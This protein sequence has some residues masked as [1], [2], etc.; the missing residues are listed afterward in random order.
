MGIGDYLFLLG[1]A[2]LVRWAFWWKRRRYLPRP[3][4]PGLRIRQA[5]ELWPQELGRPPDKRVIPRWLLQTWQGASIEELVEEDLLRLEQQIL[6]S[7]RPRQETWQ[8]ILQAAEVAL[9]LEALQK[10]RVESLPFLIQGYRPGLELVLEKLWL[11]ATVEW[12]VLRLYAWSK[13][14]D[15]VAEDWFHEFYGLA[16]AYIRE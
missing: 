13:F 4:A 11:P 1:L 12:I 7:P 5:L 3:K 10:T 8:A 15:A 2:L 9:Q 16:R 14:D 6:I